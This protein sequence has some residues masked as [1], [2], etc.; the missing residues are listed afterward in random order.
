MII[1]QRG[2]R[3]IIAQT[4]KESPFPQALEVNRKEKSDMSIFLEWII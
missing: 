1:R 2:K 4:C 3:N